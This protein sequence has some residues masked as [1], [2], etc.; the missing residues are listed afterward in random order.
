MTLIASIAGCEQSSEPTPPAAT[1]TSSTTATGDSGASSGSNGEVFVP[2]P[3]A[4]A[5]ASLTDVPTFHTPEALI[6]YLQ[7]ILAR[8]MHPV[9]EWYSLLWYDTTKEDERNCYYFVGHFTVP[10][11]LLAQAVSRNFN[12]PYRI[13]KA[14]M[15]PHQIMIP[16]QLNPDRVEVECKDDT[17][18]LEYM[19]L[20]RIGDRWMIDIATYKTVQMWERQA[21]F[22]KTSW[23]QLNT[24]PS[25]MQSV[26][27]KMDAGDFAD[28]GEAM[29]AAEMLL[30]GGKLREGEP[31]EP[32]VTTTE[33]PKPDDGPAP[34][35]GG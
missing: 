2:D 13:S 26:I 25:E 27:R 31:P 29:R 34:N 14:P 22:H 18:R 23:D 19:Y 12:E 35:P 3:A 6:A 24:V 15:Y 10:R 28:A 32:T 11:F 4:V 20:R 5:E 1:Q 17:G 9:R 8:P 16:T 21:E 30:P 7:E 33:I